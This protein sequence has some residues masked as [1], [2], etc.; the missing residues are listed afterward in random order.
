MTTF[1]R[2]RS[3]LFALGLCPVITT[4]LLAAD[5]D[6]VLVQRATKIVAVLDLA[7]ADQAGRVRDIVAH[8]Y[9]DLRPVHDARD[10]ALAA[11][12]SLAEPAPREAAT[13]AARDTATARQAELTAA[14]V[15]RLAAEIPADQID[16]IK[17]GLTYGVLPNTFRVY[18]EMLPDLTPEQSRQLYAWLYEA[19]EHAISAGSSDEKHGWFGKYKGRIN[20]YL[21]AAGIDMKAAEKAMLERRKAAP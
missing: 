3:A 12:K 20:N 10:A 2:F 19:R 1:P 8:Y 21:A 13:V 4:V 9:A 18:Q 15:G 5:P 14:F 17:D 11:A 6:D 7:D 16:R